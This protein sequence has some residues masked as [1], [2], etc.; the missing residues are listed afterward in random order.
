MLAE[1]RSNRQ[2]RI[3]KKMINNDRDDTNYWIGIF[4]KSFSFKSL[5]KMICLSIIFLYFFIISTKLWPFLLGLTDERREGEFVWQSDNEEVQFSNWNKN[6]P[7]NLKDQEDCVVLR[8]T[9]SFEWNDVRCYNNGDAGAKTRA[10]CQKYWFLY[11][12]YYI[13]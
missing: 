11:A 5:F 6:E 2:N 7:N 10:L 3:I 8:K 13:F 1:P 9:R 4:W 12:I